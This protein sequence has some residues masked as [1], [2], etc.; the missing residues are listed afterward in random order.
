MDKKKLAEYAQTI[1]DR[2]INDAKVS[3]DE[4]PILI[5]LTLQAIHTWMKSQE[6]ITKFVTNAKQINGVYTA[7]TK[8]SKSAYGSTQFDS[9]GY[10]CG[11]KTVDLSKIQNKFPAIEFK[12]IYDTHNLTVC[13]RTKGSTGWH[14]D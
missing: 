13:F 14:G 2:I 9:H 4:T 7:L 3:I 12:I 10:I 5:G 6:T 11:L 1:A 8:A